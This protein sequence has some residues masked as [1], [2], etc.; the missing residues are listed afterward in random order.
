MKRMDISSTKGKFE[1]LSE[2]LS[3]SLE[4]NNGIVEMLGHLTELAVEHP[5]ATKAVEFMLLT[6]SSIAV[7]IKDVQQRVARVNIQLSLETEDV[8]D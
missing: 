8:N 2:A 6:L 7:K 5:E 1:V 3:F 4:A